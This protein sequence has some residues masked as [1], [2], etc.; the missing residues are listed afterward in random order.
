MCDWQVGLKNC[1]Y[2]AYS[3]Y[4]QQQQ[5]QKMRRRAAK[6]EAALESL[7]FSQWA[8]TNVA[9]GLRVL[10]TPKQIND[11]LSEGHRVE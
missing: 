5:H 3:E 2:A 4:S 1:H 10:V 6:E 9:K 8:M 7:H 11:K